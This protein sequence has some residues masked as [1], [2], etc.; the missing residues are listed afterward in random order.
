MKSLEGGF[1]NFY[2]QCNIMNNTDQPSKVK[3]VR[4]SLI[5][6]LGILSLFPF[7]KSGLFNKRKDVMS[8]GP[9]A[10]TPVKMLTQ[11]GR[12]VEIDPSKIA[13]SKGKATTDEMKSWIKKEA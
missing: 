9:I 10:Q 11:D 2:F 3:R 6:G 7:L 5:A 13:S 12:L 1:L 4:R 8:C